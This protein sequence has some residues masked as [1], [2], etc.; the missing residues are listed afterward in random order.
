MLA[1]LGVATAVTTASPTGSSPTG[2]SSAATSATSPSNVS[3]HNVGGFLMPVIIV[4]TGTTTT[5]VPGPDQWPPGDLMPPW[6]YV[7][8]AV[9]LFFIGFFGFFLNLFVIALMCKEVQLWTPMNIILL[10]LV[11]SDFSVSIVGNPFTLSSAISHRW[12]FGR[13]L[14]VAYG[15]FMSLLGI[16]SITTLTVLSYERFY[17]I[18]RPFS[19]RSLSRRGALGAVLLIWCYSFA[20]TSPPL[21]GWGAY[22]SEAANISCSVNWETQTL[23]A[24]TYII[25]LFVFGLVVPLTIIVYSYTN[26]IVNMKKNAARVGRINRAEKRVTTMV[27]VM[28]IAFMVAWTPYSVFALVEQFGPPDVIGPGLA[29]LPALIAKSSICYNPIIY[30]GMNTQFRAAFNR[31][32]NHDPGD[33]ANTTTNQKEL[34]R[35]S[36]DVAV[37]CSF[38]FCRKKNRLKM[39][40]HNSIHRS[41]AIKAGRPPS[42]HSESERSSSGA[43]QERSTRVQT[44][45]NATVDSRSISGSTAKLMKSDFELSVINSGSLGLDRRTHGRIGQSTES[46]IV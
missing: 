23:N 24:T 41:A 44:M 10:N 36:R 25:Y 17:L 8:T 1:N 45:L 37:D 27:A 19:S 9:V 11:C 42:P 43:T 38:D 22:V 20:L 28:V 15:F 4:A 31:V 12:L 35:S 7:A 46:I 32:R 39:K 2:T 33:L 5:I 3:G 21:F 26:I 14:C 40:L 29:V 18:S 6:A 16:T 30:V 34:T 13:K